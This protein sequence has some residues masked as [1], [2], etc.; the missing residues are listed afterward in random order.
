[1]LSVPAALLLGGR[2]FAGDSAPERQTLQG[3]KGISVLVED[4]TTD[5]DRLL[6]VEQI[7]TD[8]ELRLR[9]AGIKVLENSFP[10]LYV[11]ANVMKGRSEVEGLYIYSCNVTFEQTV[12]VRANSVI[13]L[14]TTWSVSSLGMVGGDNMSRS[15][16]N[17]VGDLVDDFLNAY[18]SVNGTRP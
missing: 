2:L 15:V 3:I 11:S 4:L 8:V 7:R 10:I 1:M 12:S 17:V 18:L 9:K 14:G 13:A 6:T 16:R 5:V